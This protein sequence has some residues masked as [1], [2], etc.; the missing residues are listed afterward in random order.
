MNARRFHLFAPVLP[1][2]GPVNCCPE[3]TRHG[4]IAVAKLVAHDSRRQ[5][6]IKPEMVVGGRCQPIEETPL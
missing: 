4:C 6:L 1:G 5:S 2:V 3:H